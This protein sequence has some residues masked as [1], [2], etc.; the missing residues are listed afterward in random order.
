MVRA[1]YSARCSMERGWLGLTSNDNGH[2]K[3]PKFDNENEHRRLHI[4]TLQTFLVR[5]HK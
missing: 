1:R 5:F 3:E 2:H 4:D